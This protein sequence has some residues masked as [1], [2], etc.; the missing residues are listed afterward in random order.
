VLGF[1]LVGAAA[2]ALVRGPRP[3]KLLWLIAGMALIWSLDVV[4]IVVIFVA[5]DLWGENFSIDVLHPV[6]GLLF[7]SLGV[8]GMI[9]LMPRFRLQLLG[10][11]TVTPSTAEPQPAVR[12]TRPRIRPQPAVR[13]AGV[14]LLVLAVAAAGVAVADFGLG[15]YQLL[16]QDLG[17][18][19]VQPVTLVDA[20]VPGWALR[21]VATYDFDKVEFG[22]NS[23]WD[24]YIYLPGSASTVPQTVPITLD[25]IST[26]D[27]GSFSTYTVA[28]C[29]HFHGYTETD[30][31]TADLG[32][33][34]VASTVVYEVQGGLWWAAVYWEWPVTTA[35]GETYQRIVLNELA[36]VNPTGSEAALVS[37]ARSVVSAT[38]QESA[39]P[40]SA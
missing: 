30:Q 10:P 40:S 22:T 5:A 2:A 9:L 39:V 34:V 15:Q 6:V 11:A 12:P 37:F 29:Y 19:R 23:T 24:R 8:L 32:G 16:A 1:L 35:S 36:T 33:G 13:R 38:G 3:L 17:P 25:V 14:P 18:P 20:A 27:L 31:A 28:D 7:F 4:R 26:S 21:F